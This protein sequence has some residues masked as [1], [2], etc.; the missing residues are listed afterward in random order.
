MSKLPIFDA[1]L[2]YLVQDRHFSAYTAKCYNADLRPDLNPG[3]LQGEARITPRLPV[4]E[5]R[6]LPGGFG[7]SGATRPLEP[8]H[9]EPSLWR[10]P[11]SPLAL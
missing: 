5:H 8:T 3:P 10:A 1:F 9:A 7:E 11:P 4:G 6:V 2:N